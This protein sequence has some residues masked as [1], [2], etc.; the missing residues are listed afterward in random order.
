[1]VPVLMTL[2]D[3]S[4]RFQGHDIVQRAL[5]ATLAAGEAAGQL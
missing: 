1:M 4:P 3:L 2:G 5:L